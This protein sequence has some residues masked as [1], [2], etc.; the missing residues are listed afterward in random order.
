MT[1]THV[2]CAAIEQADQSSIFN[3]NIYFT[4]QVKDD[5]VRAVMNQNPEA[6]D[7]ISGLRART[8]F[9]RPKWDGIFADLK[10]RHHGQSASLVVL[11]SLR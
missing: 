9:A 1:P 5:E 4:G 6:P 11:T 2:S 8:N 10:N 7:P 3:F